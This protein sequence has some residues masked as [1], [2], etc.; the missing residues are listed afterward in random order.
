MDLNSNFTQGGPNME[1]VTEG[2]KML[3]NEIYNLYSCPNTITVITSRRMR[4]V[5]HVACIER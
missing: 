5:V 4:W 2:W 1:E 3:Y